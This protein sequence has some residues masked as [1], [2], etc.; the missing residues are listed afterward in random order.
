MHELN[1]ASASLRAALADARRGLV[2]IALVISDD[3]GRVIVLDLERE[4]RSIDLRI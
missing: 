3:R 2:G 1:S 4:Q